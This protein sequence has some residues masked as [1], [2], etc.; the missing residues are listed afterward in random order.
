MYIKFVHVTEIINHLLY[1]HAKQSITLFEHKR[2][3]YWYT[4]EKW[5]SKCQYFN[6]ITAA[7]DDNEDKDE[8]LIASELLANELKIQLEITQIMGYFTCIS[9]LFGWICFCD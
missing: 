7:D 5:V 6:T 1:V 4:E 3:L 9:I 2:I 8:K